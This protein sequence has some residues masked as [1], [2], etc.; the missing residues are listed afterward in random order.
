MEPSTGEPC[1]D[2]SSEPIKSWVSSQV[3]LAQVLGVD[4]QTIRAWLK[5]EG[6][7]GKRPDDRYDVA[8]WRAW[9]AANS[10]KTTEPVAVALDG[11]GKSKT[12]LQME[13][14]QR[15]INRLKEDEERLRIANE[16]ERGDLISIDEF[17]QI[18]G[19]AWAAMTNSLKQ[20][21]HRIS[22]QVVGLDSGAASK[23]IKKDLEE[24][25]RKFRVPEGVK[26]KRFWR[27]SSRILEDLQ[28]KLS[29][30]DGPKQTASRQSRPR[31]RSTTQAKQSSSE[32]S[33]SASKMT[34]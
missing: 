32:E 18:V 26:K 27:T 14:L 15:E 1:Q 25:L 20:T 29:L 8:D 34:K 30:G 28:G 23:V 11:A 9:Q 33:S 5:V 4:R 21:H 2:G 6:N 31:A 7:P 12:E 10:S 19:D 16:V 24:T 22:Q 17:K 13:K 3:A